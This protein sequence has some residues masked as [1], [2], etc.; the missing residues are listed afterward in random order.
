VRMRLPVSTCGEFWV[1]LALRLSMLPGV[2]GLAV[3][4]GAP[5]DA[6]PGPGQDA[7]GVGVIASAR[8]GAGVDVGGPR[9][10]VPGVVGEA[11]QRRS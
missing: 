2:I 8:S 4:P 3:G 10:L 1:C 5:E 9:A 11:G 6:D 7:D